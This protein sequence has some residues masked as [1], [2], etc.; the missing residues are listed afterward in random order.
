[1]VFARKIKG[2]VAHFEIKGRHQTITN[3]GAMA[4]FIATFATAIVFFFWL[5]GVFFTTIF[6]VRF[7]G[8]FACT[9][10]FL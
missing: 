4:R 2:K 6:C 10:A 1:M 3:S 8:C 9:A 7:L 5:V